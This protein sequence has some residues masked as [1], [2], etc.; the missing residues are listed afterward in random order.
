[1]V[2]GTQLVLNKCQGMDEGV[3]EGTFFLPSFY[4][5]LS[6]CA[7]PGLTHV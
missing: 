3:H 6:P 2:L 4:P 7:I 1:M 5:T